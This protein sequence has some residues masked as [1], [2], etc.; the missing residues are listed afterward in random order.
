MA[1]LGP[2]VAPVIETETDDEDED[3]LHGCIIIEDD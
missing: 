2:I 1:L 3:R